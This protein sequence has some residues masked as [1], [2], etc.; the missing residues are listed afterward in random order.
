MLQNLP[1]EIE[2]CKIAHMFSVETH[3]KCDTVKAGK[4]E[5]WN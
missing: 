4:P 3:G 1:T 5:P 2:L